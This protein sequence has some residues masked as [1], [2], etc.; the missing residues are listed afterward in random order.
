MTATIE[1]ELPVEDHVGTEVTHLVWDEKPDVALCGADVTGQRWSIGAGPPPCS[2]CER[3]A[4]WWWKLEGALDAAQ[5][6][7]DHPRG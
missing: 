6:G 2:A 1:L 5:H 3:E 7:T 4:Q